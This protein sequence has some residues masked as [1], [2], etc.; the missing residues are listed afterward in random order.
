M[1]MSVA[2]DYGITQVVHGNWGVHTII[3]KS[4]FAGEA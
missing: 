1:M 4:L 2:V 3:K